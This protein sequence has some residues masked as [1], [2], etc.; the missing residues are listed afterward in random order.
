MIGRRCLLQTNESMLLN[1]LKVTLRGYLR[2]KSFTWINLASQAVGLFVAFMAVNYIRYELSYDTFHENADSIY[3]L[4]RT[5]RSQDYGIIGFA[6]WNDATGEEQRAQ[7][8][9]LKRVTG[10]QNAVQFITSDATEFLE[11]ENQQVQV[12]KILTTNTPDAF[13]DVFSWQVRQG[14]LQNFATGFDKV[15]LTATTAQKLLGPDALN[16]PDLSQMQVRLAGKVYALAAIVDDVPLNSHFDFNIAVSQPRLDYWGSRMYV[17]L[18]DQAQKTTVEEQIN[19]AIPGMFPRLSSDPLYQKHFLQPITG[20]HLDSNILYESKPPG[21]RTYLVLIGGF[22]LFIIIITLFNYA[23]LSLALKSKQSKSIGVRKALGATQSGIG[24]QFLS[25]GVLLSFLALPVVGLL[26]LVLIPPFNDLMGVNLPTTLFS[27]PGTWLTLIGLAVGIGFLSSMLPVILLSRK[28]A[29]SLFK[30]T[31]RSNLYQNFP[32]RKYLVTSQLIILISITSVSYFVTRQLEFIENKELGFQKE[33]ILYA[34]SSPENQ[35]VFQEKL[36]QL[37]G[38]VQVGNGSPFGIEPFNQIT[39]QLKGTNEVYD[40]ASQLYLDNNAL[41]AYD[42]KF[43]SRATGGAVFANRSLLINRTAAQKIADKEN[44]TLGDLVGKTIV[45]EPEYVAENGEQGFPFTIAGVFEDINL[46]SLHEKVEPYFILI[47]DNV[48]MNG[49]SIV[50]YS[51]AASS[52]ILAQIQKVYDEMREPFPLEVEYLDAN[53]DELYR[54]DRRTANLLVCFNVIA[55]LLASLGI[56]GISMFLTIARTK[57]IGIRKVL[58][59]SPLSIIRSATQ[60]YV[61]LV[62]WALLISVPIGFYVVNTWL[63]NF[64][65][66]IEFNPSVFAGAGIFTLALTVLIVGIISYRAALVN[67]VQ[68]LRSE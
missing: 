39:Y 40:D 9:S 36:R 5:Y 10:I 63:N 66:H 37:P 14:S 22:A 2:N 43:I 33:N 55:V 35:D 34:Y 17:Q 50:R 13:V 56:I 30:D 51:E 26:G 38:V 20:I 11:A 25:E 59:A 49:R 68:S 60:E 24:W 1:F 23:N 16:N 28:S 4:A 47:S 32:I 52:D 6:T 7:I 65:Y 41:Q 27:D 64:A 31:L 21:N 18:A 29:V 45:T 57:E 67:P 12:N 58:G 15:I 54:T 42:L 48:R 62:I 61:I 3:R 19:A 53:V 46:F 44:L 8:E